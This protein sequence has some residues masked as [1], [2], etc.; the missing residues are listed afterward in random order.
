M[1]S[2]FDCQHLVSMPVVC[3]VAEEWVNA[4]LAPVA[5]GIERWKW[6]GERRESEELIDVDSRLEN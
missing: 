1:K 5:W 3:A 2:E 6:D 4:P